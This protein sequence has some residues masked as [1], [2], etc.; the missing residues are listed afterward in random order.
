MNDTPDIGMGMEVYF[1]SHVYSPPWSP[2][3]DA[4]KGHKFKVVGIHE[5]DHIE[6]QCVTG[7][8]KVSGHVHKQDLKRV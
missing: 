5:G 4:Y 8:V 3:F 7:D 6:L 1:R 2:Y